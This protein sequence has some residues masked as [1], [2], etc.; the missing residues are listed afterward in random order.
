MDSDDLLRE[1][2]RRAA[3]QGEPT[4]TLEEVD[5]RSELMYRRRMV[6]ATRPTPRQEP[7][8]LRSAR[9]V[10][11]SVPSS[12]R[13][14][15]RAARRRARSQSSVGVGGQLGHRFF[16]TSS[17]SYIDTRFIVSAVCRLWVKYARSTGLTT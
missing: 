14:K 6:S 5:I 17:G 9:S 7:S 1:P 11:N 15:P 16:V 4:A 2:V 12:R 13:A 8:Q 10:G 3:D